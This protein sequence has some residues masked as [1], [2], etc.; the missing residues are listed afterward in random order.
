MPEDIHHTNDVDI[1]F[2]GE[3]EIAFQEVFAS[4]D[5]DKIC[6]VTYRQD[7]HKIKFT[8]PREYIKDHDSLLSPP[9]ASCL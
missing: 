6:G 1:V 8:P 3:G 7:N 4:R 5:W 2:I 9:V